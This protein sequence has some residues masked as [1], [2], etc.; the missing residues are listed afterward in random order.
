M[1]KCKFCK[2]QAFMGVRVYGYHKFGCCEECMLWI[3]PEIDIL[4][5]KSCCKQQPKEKAE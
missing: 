2:N 1:T 3:F 4:N 5:E